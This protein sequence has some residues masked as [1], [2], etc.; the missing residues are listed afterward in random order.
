MAL[1]VLA[2]DKPMY[3]VVVPSS[4]E[5]FK[6]RPF[7]VKEQKSM[8]IA[9]ESKDNKQILNTMLNCVESCIPGLDA[10]RL[11][12]F[13]MDYI[14]TQ[15]RAKSV[16]ET[17][18]VRA[19]CIKCNEDNEVTI[20][21]EK[22]KM[23]K[24]EM[25]SQIVPITD[26]IRLEMKFPT[27][28]DVLKSPNYMKDD[29]NQVEELFDSIST[30]LYAVQSGDDNIL[31][32]EE[33]KEEIEKFINSLNTKQL[34]KIAQFIEKIPTL[35]HEEKFKCVKCNHENTLRLKGIQDFF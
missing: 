34:E 20:N 24:A 30:C 7:L 5:T 29:S 14:F 8:L 31:V 17:S 9:F 11:A 22:I 2:N 25:K 13:D 16:G 6:F 18:K 23:E 28:D 35:T 4:Q 33:P 3:E 1:P 12:T 27:Y 10:K 19:A 15:I 32:S 26:T 21:L